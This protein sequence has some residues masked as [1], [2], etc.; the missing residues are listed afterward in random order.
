M[1]NFPLVSLIIPNYNSAQ[2]L[3]ETLESALGASY[4]AIEIIIVDD[5]STDQSALILEEWKSNFPNQIKVYYQCNQGP[6]IARNFGIHQAS[7]TYILPLDSDDKIHPDYISQAVEKIQNSPEVKVVY[8]EAE[9]FGM[10]NEHWKL[11][12]FSL[13]DLALDNMIFVSA[14]FKKSDWKKTGGYDPRFICGWEDWEFWIN[15]L[16][17]GGKV[18]KLPM[19][20]FYYRIRKGSR[21]KSTNQAGKLMTI[22]LLNRKHPEFFGAF[23]Y[24]PIRNPRGISKLVNPFVNLFNL[25]T[26]FSPAIHNLG[27]AKK[28]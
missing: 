27:I 28:Y 11:K 20:G 1:S 12:P 18:V 16:K 23:L 2:F 15:M 8:C 10:K 6:S 21:R 5:G 26:T 14:L 13:R 4:P 22:Q 24:G 25:T 7:G 19:V 3:A 17:N 9:K